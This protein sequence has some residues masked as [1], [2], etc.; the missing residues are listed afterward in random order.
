MAKRRSAEF[1]PGKSGT[2]E[3]LPSE[4]ERERSITK[5]INALLLET[6]QAIDEIGNPLEGESA[7]EANHRKTVWRLVGHDSR[8]QRMGRDLAGR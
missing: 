4:P 5:S 2:F 1:S 6:A 8:G 7:E 3:T